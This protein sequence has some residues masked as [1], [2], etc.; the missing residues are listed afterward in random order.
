M[1]ELMPE[2][3][4]LMDLAMMRIIYRTCQ[5]WQNLNTN[6]TVLE[7]LIFDLDYFSIKLKLQ[8]NLKCFIIELTD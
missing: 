7:I 5:K 4:N 8:L 6:I 1:P 2:Q 3:L